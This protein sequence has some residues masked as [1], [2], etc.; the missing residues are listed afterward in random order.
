MDGKRLA[1]LAIEAAGASSPRAALRLLAD[2]R[3]E[4]DEFERRQVARALA[5][6]ASYAAVAR[7]LGLSRQA[8]HRRFRDVGDEELPLLMAPDARRVLRLARQEA[9]AMGSAEPGGEHLLLAALRSPAAD[10]LEAAD[11]TADRARSQVT[12]AAAPGGLFAPESTGDQRALLA[13]AADAARAR[14]ARRI[15]VE[16]VLFA[17]LED[18]EGG[19]ARTLRAL[20]VDPSEV[21]AALSRRSVD[22]PARTAPE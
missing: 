14:G 1:L 3:R 12:G 7:D 16:D 19:A 11:V 10:L 5:E 8:V 22:P 4:I 6:G 13:P 2:L 9:A 21:R 20:G 15:E 17:A 18:P